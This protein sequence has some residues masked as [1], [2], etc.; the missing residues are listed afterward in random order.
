[1][2]ISASCNNRTACCVL[3]LSASQLASGTQ[4]AVGSPSR[5]A[6][7]MICLLLQV[8]GKEVKT[9]KMLWQR[10]LAA[11]ARRSGV[12]QLAGGAGKMQIVEVSC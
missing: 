12:L 7:A 8:C 1:M 3:L 9:S 10:C 11:K 4:E 6:V 5:S 2:L